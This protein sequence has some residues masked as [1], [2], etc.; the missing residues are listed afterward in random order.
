MEWASHVVKNR[1]LSV[2][3]KYISTF[4]PNSQFNE[5]IKLCGHLFNVKGVRMRDPP[6]PVQGYLHVSGAPSLALSTD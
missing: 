2:V 6:P 4:N 3:F 5:L 1:C